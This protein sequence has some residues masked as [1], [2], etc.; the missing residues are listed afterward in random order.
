MQGQRLQRQSAEGNFAE[1]TM[2]PIQARLAV[3][4]SP[5]APARR[6]RQLLARAT[7]ALNVYSERRALKE[8]DDRALKD[9]GCTRGDAAQEGAR[10]FW[11]LPD[12]SW[13]R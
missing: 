2:A 4:R 8:L 7:F 1:D 5:I 10:A 3:A 13:G 12:R 11:D 9:M 6:L